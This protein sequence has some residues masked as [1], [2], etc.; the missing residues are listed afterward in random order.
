MGA[1]VFEKIVTCYDI[2]TIRLSLKALL[3]RML[4]RGRVPD[5]EPDRD[6]QTRE[7]KLGF[8]VKR[9]SLRFFFCLQI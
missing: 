7:D 4:K 2:R 8:C 5:N 3:N 1:A 6:I 9:Y